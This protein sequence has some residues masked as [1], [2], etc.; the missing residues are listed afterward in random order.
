MANDI[1]ELKVKTNEN[2]LKFKLI[3]EEGNDTGEYLTFDLEDM[4]CALRYQE[5]IEEHRKNAEYLKNQQVIISKQE[6][7]KGKKLLSS[8]EEKMQKALAEYFDREIKAL[9]LVLGEGKTRLILKIMGRNPYLSMFEDINEMLEPI[10]PYIEKSYENIKQK[11][12]G[13]YK[14]E[15]NILE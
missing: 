12:V 15:P 1:R 4:N 11:I 9:D 14:D 3:D 13:K 2:L 5:M 7:H 6:D 10:T 8:N